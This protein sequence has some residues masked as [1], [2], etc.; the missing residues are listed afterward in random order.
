MKIGKISVIKKEVSNS[1]MKT[2]D[3]ELL[4]NNMTRMP[5]TGSFRFPYKE[6]DGKYRTGLDVNAAYIQR[7]QD[8][9]EKQI[10]IER[11]EFTLKRL[12]ET[13]GDIDLS[14]RSK[15]WNY[16]LSV[17]NDDNMHVKPVKLLDGDNF[18]DFKN[19]FKEIEFYWL[20]A[21][22]SIASSYQAWERGEYPAD[23]QF[24]VVD[25]DLEN[26]ILFK[27]K[28]LIN[29][30]IAKFDIMSP[31]KKKKVARLLGLPVTEN[32]KEE[33]VY[34]MVDNLLKEKEFQKGP[35]SGKSTVDMFNRFADMKENL[36]HIK[37]LIKQALLHSI[38]RVKPNGK[39]FEGELEIAKDEEELVKFLVN[40][41]NQE[42]LLAL[43]SK[44]KVKK[45]AAV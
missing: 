41:D 13:L 30:A 27:K 2:I 45:I 5:G 24:Y 35:F 14:P 18:F 23:T 8:P 16:S 31:E 22:P 43:E 15:F 11:I 4:H 19:P 33:Q 28:Q 6:L 44:L 9:I 38:Y 34:N 36:L 32:S 37:D 21:H 10:E 39:I 26:T 20:K 1:G 40:E 17:G 3:T 12:K 7:I 25:D 29:K 42:D